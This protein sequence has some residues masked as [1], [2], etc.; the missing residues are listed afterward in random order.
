M[1]KPFDELNMDILSNSKARLTLTHYQP[2][3]L[4]FRHISPADRLQFAYSTLKHREF[5]A[6]FRPAPRVA[7]DVMRGAE[8]A[9]PRPPS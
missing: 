3:H 4:L 1:F 2:P 5:S 9:A 7:A 8:L 6:C